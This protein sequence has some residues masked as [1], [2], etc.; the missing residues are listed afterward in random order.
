M[1]GIIGY[2]GDKQAAPFLLA[3][4]KRLEYRGYDSSGIGIVDARTKSFDVRKINGKIANLENLIHSQPL[5]ESSTGISHT[6]WAT[7]G[8]PTRINAHPHVDTRKNILVVHNG[9]IEN[10]ESLREKLQSRGH[11]F[12]SQTDTEVV[13][14]LIGEYYHPSRSSAKPED[15]L[16]AVRKAVKQ[17]KGAFALGVI[18]ADQPGVL[19]AARVGSPLIIGLGRGEQFIASDV[20]AIF[21]HTK[22]IIYLKDGQMALLTPQCVQVSSFDGHKVQPKVDTVN[23]QIDAVQ[24]QGFAHFMLKEI[25]EQPQVLKQMFHARVKHGEVVL[26]GIHLT[27]QQLKNIK[28]ILIVACGTAY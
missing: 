9:I 25:H 18:A 15:L 17:L 11:R 28:R 21:Q 27:D 12:V 24:K 19:V 22:K 26:S 4:L 20:P 10:Y 14:Q 6:R 1:C 2:V 16:A 5:C 7:H 13:A 3:G 8:A 23:L